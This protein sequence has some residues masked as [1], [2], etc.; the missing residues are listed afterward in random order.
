MILARQNSKYS[1][2]KKLIIKE[3][4]ATSKF[5]DDDSFSSFEVDDAEPDP[6]L[7]TKESHSYV[8][9]PQAI[10]KDEAL[11]RLN[12]TAQKKKSPST[13]CGSPKRR[14]FSFADE[15]S[16][17][18]QRSQVLEAATKEKQRAPSVLSGLMN[19]FS[20]LRHNSV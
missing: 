19:V 2:Q 18:E 6:L 8:E 4:Q 10:S 17:F 9:I 12:F 15:D 14:V 3:D 5:G 11:A 20:C 1:Q 16:Q 7:R 13:R